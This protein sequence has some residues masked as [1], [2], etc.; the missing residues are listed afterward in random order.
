M[1]DTRYLLNQRPRRV[2]LYIAKY[3]AP[4]LIELASR[5]DQRNDYNP[6]V[7]LLFLP[8]PPPI[9]NRDLSSLS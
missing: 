5:K 7:R 6:L 3:N 1:S 8:P 9:A 2:K 4:Q